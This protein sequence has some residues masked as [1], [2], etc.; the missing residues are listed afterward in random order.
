VR[1][2]VATRPISWLSA[3]TLARLDRVLDRFGGPSRSIA[4][5]AAGLP[6]VTLT[7]VGVKT[8]QRRTARVLGIPDGERMV[9]IASNFGQRHHPAWYY[10]LRADPSAELTV[11]GMTR[12]VR[13]REAIGAERAR[14]WESALQ[15]YPGWRNYERRASHREIGVFILEPVN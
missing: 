15:V 9:V 14:L 11:D 5:L 1:R 8:G 10:N 4:S 2:L 13:A 6:V 12:R 3:H 7:T